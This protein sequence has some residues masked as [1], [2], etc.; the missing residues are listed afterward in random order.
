MSL[1]IRNVTYLGLKR[2]KTI[3]LKMRNLQCVSLDISKCPDF[4]AIA[5]T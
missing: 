4:V 2:N 3:I 1:T 5:V